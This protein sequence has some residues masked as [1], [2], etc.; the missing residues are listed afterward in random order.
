VHGDFPIPMPAPEKSATAQGEQVKVSF[1]L[2]GEQVKAL[3]CK[4]DGKCF[5]CV[6]KAAC[7][8]AAT[9][10][11]GPGTRSNPK[12]TLNVIEPDLALYVP[13]VGGYNRHEA[14]LWASCN[15][16]EENGMWGLLVFKEDELQ[17]KRGLQNGVLMVYVNGKYFKTF[18]EADAR[19]GFLGLNYHN[20]PITGNS[21]IMVVF[22][23]TDS[24]K[25]ASADIRLVARNVRPNTDSCMGAK[26]CL[27]LLVGSD[28]AFALRN[29]NELQWQ[30][31]MADSSVTRIATSSACDPWF[32]CLSTAEQ[33]DKMKTFLGAAMRLL[34]D[35]LGQKNSLVSEATE[36][37]S[38]TDSSCIDPSTE[39]PESWE[40]ECF[41]EMSK[42]C[43]VPNQEDCIRELMCNKCS[44]CL[45]WKQTHCSSDSV[46]KHEEEC[47]GNVAGTSSL[48]MQ[49]GENNETTKEKGNMGGTLQ[50][51]LKGKC[52]SET[53]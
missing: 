4:D 12:G 36:S 49:R 16:D 22:V 34:P 31:L 33:L 7:F 44:L 19:S 26:D 2:R 25:A 42:S 41:D 40:C 20:I 28:A 17:N 24:A 8:N 3:Y 15:G 47:T 52:S 18:S 53:Q 37:V 11:Y 6:K 29:S 10:S 45:A 23:R 32:E 39:D 9:Y 51:T 21:H 5:G 38:A 48:L 50:D 35:S 14:H 30:C 43:D 1:K 13:A 46:T 27:S